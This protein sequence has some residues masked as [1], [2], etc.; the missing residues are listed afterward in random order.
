MTRTGESKRAEVE[1]EASK[2]R[3]PRLEQSAERNSEIRS[4]RALV[5]RYWSTKALLGR[6]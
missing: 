6:Y 2:E 1:E 3:P 5:R 4:V